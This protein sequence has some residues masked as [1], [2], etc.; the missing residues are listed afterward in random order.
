M[1]NQA[2]KELNFDL[3]EMTYSLSGENGDAQYFSIDYILIIMSQKV[4]EF[5]T[6][7]VFVYFDKST[8]FG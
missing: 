5:L 2:L 7:Y 3:L 8:S 1:P 6:Y 4:R